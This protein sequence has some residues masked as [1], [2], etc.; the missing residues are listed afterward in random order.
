M[1]GHPGRGKSFKYPWIGIA[2]PGA[3]GKRMWN[4]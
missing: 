3:R 2:G 4:F 1:I